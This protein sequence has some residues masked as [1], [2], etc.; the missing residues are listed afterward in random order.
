MYIQLVA[1][2]FT[3]HK[4]H[5]LILYFIFPHETSRVSNEYNKEK[6]N[7]SISKNRMPFNEMPH[8]FC[9]FAMCSPNPLEVSLWS[10]YKNLKL[11][12]PRDLP[13]FRLVINPKP[14]PLVLYHG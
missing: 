7:T 12:M 14:S 13:M 11:A 6:N 4:D 10:R 1:L 5:I 2:G 8:E 9:H 3:K